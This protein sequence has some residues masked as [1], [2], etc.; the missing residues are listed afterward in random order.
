MLVLTETICVDRDG[1]IF[2]KRIEPDEKIRFSYQSIEQPN[3]PVIEKAI[4]WIFEY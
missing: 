1:N 2:G 3:D 4:N